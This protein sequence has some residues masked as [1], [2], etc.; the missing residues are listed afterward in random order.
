MGRHEGEAMG[1]Q[2]DL[3]LDASLQKHK[4][5]LQ[6]VGQGVLLNIWSEVIKG[7]KK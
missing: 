6:K 1:R 4:K 2:T 7:A 5:L 3:V